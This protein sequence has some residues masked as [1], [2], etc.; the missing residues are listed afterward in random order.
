MI[1]VIASVKV[2]PG[3]VDEFLEVLN[4][5]VPKVREERGCIEY[6]PTV[7]IDSGLPPQI[8]DEHVVTILEQWES[9]EALRAHLATPHMVAY[10]EKVKNI[11]EDVSLKV[12]REV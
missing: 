6:V 1:Y 8:V 9:P 5:N 3:K 7:D 11:I 12:L 2:R 4:S 10:K